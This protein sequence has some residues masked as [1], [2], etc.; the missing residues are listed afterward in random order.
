[1]ITRRRVIPPLALA[2]S[3]IVRAD[4]A[5]IRIAV[6]A[7]LLRDVNG[8]DIRAAMRAWAEAITAETG[9]QVMEYNRDLIASNADLNDAVRR[10]AVDAVA[11]IVPEYLRLT[12]YLDP[13]SLLVDETTSNGGY[14]LVVLAHRRRGIRSA[15]DLKG[16]TVTI[17][18]CPRTSL[19]SAWLD[20]LV[21]DVAPMGFDAY[22]TVS[23]QGKLSKVILPVFFQQ[24]DAC[25][26][27]RLAFRTMCEL[28][29]QL[30]RDL[31]IIAQSPGMAA[32]AFAFHRQMP[33]GVREA[34]RTALTNLHL[35][36]AGKQALTL[37]QSGHLVR[38]D[39]SVLRSAVQ[40]LQAAERL[41]AKRPVR[42]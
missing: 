36:A 11:L 19:M 27:D 24:A 34:F 29:P 9:F 35:S 40:I 28:N 37:F 25:V 8:N 21:A 2:L 20:T 22:S 23:Y 33:A 16:R 39:A 4:T 31:E 15:A 12:A 13:N 38:A 32:S 30:T 6:S 17:H 5:R 18:S 41:R 14:E 1:M 42:Q 26:A 10:F 3:P 7:T